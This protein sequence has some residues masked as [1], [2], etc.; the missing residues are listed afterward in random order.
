MRFVVVC[1]INWMPSGF[2]MQAAGEHKRIQQEVYAITG[3]HVP[4]DDVMILAALFYAQKMQDAGRDAAGQ[5][6]TAGALTRAAVS[7]ATALLRRSVESNKA[8]ADAFEARLHKVVRQVTKAQPSQEGPPQGW[9]GVLAGVALG[10]FITGGAML[11]ACNFRLSWFSDARFGAEWAVV[12]PS[13]P[14][15]LRDKMIEHYQKHRR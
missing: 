5:I 10:I 9:K 6:T 3:K 1:S 7:E 8:L 12:L 4:E 14:P 2:N 11:V 13:L 15:D